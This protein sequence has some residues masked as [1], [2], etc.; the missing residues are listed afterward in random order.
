MINRLAS[1]TGTTRLIMSKLHPPPINNR[2]QNLPQCLLSIWHFPSF[3]QLLLGVHCTR[4]LNQECPPAV[5]EKAVSGRI[6]WRLAAIE[7]YRGWI[8][9]EDLVFYWLKYSF[10]Y[11][12]LHFIPTFQMWRNMFVKNSIPS[13]SMF[14]ARYNTLQRIS[15]ITFFAS[16]TTCMVHILVGIT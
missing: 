2:K 7:L 10:E 6:I 5:E 13:W 16:Y 8:A 1:T 9:M 15:M 11:Q 12:E 3:H 4:G 14:W